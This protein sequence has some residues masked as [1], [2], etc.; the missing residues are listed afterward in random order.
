[1]NRAGLTEL[2]AGREANKLTGRDSVAW[3]GTGVVDEEGCSQKASGRRWP[4]AAV[5]LE[6]TQEEAPK[7]IEQRELRLGSLKHPG[8]VRPAWGQMSTRR[9]MSPA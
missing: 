3:R 4:T 9:A 1:V 2:Q 5:G 8:G 7:G 6:L